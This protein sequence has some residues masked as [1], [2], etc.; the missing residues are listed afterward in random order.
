MTSVIKYPKI[1]YFPRQIVISGTNKY[2]DF[3]EDGSTELTATL[4]EGTYTIGEL[5]TE[6]RKQLDAVGSSNYSVSYAPSTNYFTITSDGNGGTGVFTL[7]F[8]TGTNNANSAAATLGYASSDLSGALF[9]TST[10]VSPA[11]VT[12]EFTE[13]IRS[14]R[15]QKNARQKVNVSIS[16]VN[17]ANFVRN[18]EY[19]RF[20]MSYVEQDD[21]ADWEE[22]IEKCLMSQGQFDYYPDKDAADSIALIG[23]MNTIETNEMLREGWIGAYSFEI[24]TRV[25]KKS[26]NTPAGVSTITWAELKDRVNV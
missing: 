21:M 13:P 18:D 6:L 26:I 25:V 11:A 19:F 7:E 16:G 4:T 23:A 24:A 9:Y 22:F 17:E 10:S 14:P 8:A 12:L 5:R 1:V 2:I 20:M 3:T 15:Y